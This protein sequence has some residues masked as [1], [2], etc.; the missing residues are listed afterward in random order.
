MIVMKKGDDVDQLL[1]DFGKAEKKTQLVGK[2]NVCSDCPSM[3]LVKAQAKTIDHLKKEVEKLNISLDN[4]LTFVNGLSRDVE[5]LKLSPTSNQPVQ[6]EDTEDLNEKVEVH[7]RSCLKIAKARKNVLCSNT[8]SE[9][10]Y[11]VGRSDHEIL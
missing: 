10:I 3:E 8:P 7:P 2:S 6:T 1:S 11:S 5:V 9:F 4:V